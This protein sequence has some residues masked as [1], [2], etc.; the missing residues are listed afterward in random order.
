MVLQKVDS[1]PLLREWAKLPHMLGGNSCLLPGRGPSGS[2]VS[3]VSTSLPCL[4]SPCPRFTGS[5]QGDCPTLMHCADPFHLRVVESRSVVSSLCDPMDCRPP[6]SS[7]LGFL[8]ARILEWVPIAC[9]RDLPAPGIEPGSPALQA[10]SLPSEPP[11]RL[12][13]L[14]R[15]WRA[16]PGWELDALQGRDHPPP[17]PGAALVP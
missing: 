9:P 5:G 16:P 7:G 15:T 2:S 1:Q 13:R 11:G 12:V 6:G 14:V 17:Y 3:Q 4:F 8:Q 10:D